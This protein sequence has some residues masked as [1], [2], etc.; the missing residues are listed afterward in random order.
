MCFE[1][2]TEF[3]YYA[4]QIIENTVLVNY[5]EK[6]NKINLFWICDWVWYRKAALGF[7]INC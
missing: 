2:I 1:F 4:K 5:K 6:F 7:S 3:P